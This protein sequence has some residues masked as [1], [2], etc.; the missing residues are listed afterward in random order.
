MSNGLAPRS[1]ELVLAVYGSGKHVKLVWHP[2]AASVL[3]GRSSY[4]GP[5]ELPHNPVSVDTSPPIYASGL[6]APLSTESIPKVVVAG[7]AGDRFSV[8]TSE[9]PFPDSVFTLTVSVSV[10]TSFFFLEPFCGFR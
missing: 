4:P 5:E 3:E 1:I 10:F 6:S 8:N 7:E 2:K 9:S